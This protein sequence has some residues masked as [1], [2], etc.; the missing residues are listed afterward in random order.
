MAG[1]GVGKF[2]S[3][4]SNNT[5]NLTVN[6]AENMAPS[7]VN[8]AA[9][10]LMGHMRDMYEQLGDGYFEFG[11]GDGEYTVARS[12]ANTITITGTGDITSVYYVGRKIRITDGGANVLE[13]VINA[14]SHSSTTQTIDL[15]G[16]DL[17]SGTPTKVELGIDTAAFGGK[18]ILDDDGDTYIEAPTDDTID[19]YVAGAKD[20]VITANTFTAESGSTIAAQA[21]T[22]TTVTASGIVK[23]DD[24]TNAT[25]TTDGSLQTDGG[26]SVALD[27]VIGDDL[28]M[29]SDAAVIHF[30]ADSDV[31]MTH[32]A[33]AGL[34]IASAG[35][36]HTLQL[37]SNDADE[38][39][40]PVL[41]MFRNSGSPVDDDILGKIK[42]AGL[43]GAGNATTYGRIET[44][45]MEEA[46]GSED[47]TM[48]FRIM[49]GG[50]ERNVLE[51][52]RGEV[53]INEDGQNIDFRVESDDRT[54]M[55]HIDSANNNARFDSTNTDVSQE[56]YGLTPLVQ[57]R[58]N[59]PNNASLL[60]S[61]H[62]ADANG[63]S[64]F[65]Y[66]SRNTAPGSFTSVAANDALG[67][68]HF[69][70]DDGS[71]AGSKAALIACEIDGTPGT[72]DTPGRLTFYTT[73]DGAADSTERMRLDNYGTL[74]IGSTAKAGANAERLHVTGTTDVNDICFF[75]SS[76]LD[77]SSQIT[78]QNSARDTG[79]TDG[80][81]VVQFGL[82]DGNA[83]MR[84]YKVSDTMTASNRDI[85]LQFMV[86]RDNAM[87][88]RF[89][90]ADNG[91]LTATDTSIGSLSDVRLKKDIVDLDYSIDT[92]KALKPR[93][94]NWKN[95]AEHGGETNRL[96]FIAQELKE[97]DPYWVN[98][99]KAVKKPDDVLEPATYYVGD[100]LYTEK[101]Q[102][103]IDGNKNVGD[104]KVAGDVLPDGKKVG[105]IKTEA[106]YTYQYEKGNGSDYDLLNDG[107][108]LDNV[109]MIAKLGKKDAMYISVIQQL[110]A[111]IE[112]LEA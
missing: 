11:D 75:T 41:Q 56:V 29:K 28:F 14:S 35:N 109:E 40:G 22:A 70:A 60:I 108:E 9:R 105:D 61:E 10:E 45:I 106:T 12:D 20:F 6:F 25:S 98:E 27:A 68:I 26:L 76:H 111:R 74:I 18:V 44:L 88:V 53:I 48:E 91:D 99:Q 36:L 54:H 52:D 64:L 32:V 107:S 33:D 65:F 103:V 23:T 13:G 31:T 57:I 97:I 15:T 104:V 62:V 102:E 66:K 8:N 82:G 63:A 94:F 84:A 50:T 80:V 72:N 87:A 39:E 7:N 101:D 69:I 34:T 81:A 96:G 4:A 2:S 38:N 59:H 30:G 77:G 24:T 89:Q 86:Q 100:V 73:A 19:I 85:G 83:A 5:S 55:F 110:I 42:F 3:T 93:K 67:V 92:F 78:I 47:A 46:N 79:D 1:T 95:V 16:I 51:L 71:D 43:D 90:I 37:Q 49:S 58:G 112:A 17:A 21:L